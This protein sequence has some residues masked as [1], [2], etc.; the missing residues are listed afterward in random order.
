MSELYPHQLP[1]TPVQIEFLKQIYYDRKNFYGYHKLFEIVTQELENNPEIPRIYRNQ[2]RDWLQGQEAYQLYKPTPKR[3][4]TRA[5]YSSGLAHMLQCDSIILGNAQHSS[6]R[7]T[8]I[9]TVVDLYSRYSFAFPQKSANSKETNE[10]IAKVLEFFKSKGAT[11]KAV[12]TDN[13]TEFAKLSEIVKHIKGPPGNPTRQ[14]TV[15]R[16]NRTVRD[17]M[18]HYTFSAKNPKTWHLD[19]ADFVA[20]YNTTTHSTTK[21]KPIDVV[22]K[23]ATPAGVSTELAKSGDGLIDVGTF[24]RIVNEKRNAL[25]KQSPYWSSQ[26]YKISKVKVGGDTRRNTYYISGKGYYN[27]TQLQIVPNDSPQTVKHVPNTVQVGPDFQPRRSDRL[28]VRYE[29][30]NVLPK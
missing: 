9:L 12:M 17:W 10:N 1:L 8:T 13:G 30:V 11:V 27:N 5:I 21:V 14:A 19:I 25:D 26:I 22:D 24:V 3:V 2:V 4:D 15:E 7:H 20:T 28:K 16:W 23:K 18:R 29:A 6:Q